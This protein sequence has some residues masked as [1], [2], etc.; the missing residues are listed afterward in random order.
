MT[1]DYHTP[2]LVHE[3][4]QYLSVVPD[5]VY[6]DATLG[7]GG[8]AEQILKALSPRGKL[9]GF[10]MDA[11]ALNHAETRLREFADRLVCVHGNFAGLRQH[12]IERGFDRIQGI[13]L[14]LGVSS[15]Q[16]DTRDRGFSFQSDGRL[17]MRMNTAQRLD[18]W[19][20]LNQYDERQIAEILWKFGE[21]RNS[22]RIAKKIVMMRTAEPIQTTTQL[23]LAVES[24]VGQRWLKKSLARIFQAIRIEVN[25][26]LDNLRHVLRDA[27][28]ILEHGGRIVVVSY[29]S[30][31]DRIV[32][33]FFRENSQQHVHRGEKPLSPL[34]AQ[35]AILTKKPVQAAQ[36]ELV[37]NRRARS[38]KLRAAERI[39]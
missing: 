17:D 37:F 28:D 20:V 7:G 15:H 27:I 14:D 8:H 33:Q 38:A 5:G 1:D 9:I 11:D 30:L 29:H 6:V 36:A 12:L 16:I 39:Q 22:R 35:L 19:K 18:A 32:K 34:A 13:L 23:A 31:E 25:D 10:D 21:E 24:V 3:V 26:E 4:L 2:V